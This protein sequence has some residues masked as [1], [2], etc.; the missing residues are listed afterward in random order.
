MAASRIEEHRPELAGRV[1]EE[2]MGP[3][4]FKVP[5]GTSYL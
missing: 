5:L 4:R 2:F 3:R 1:G